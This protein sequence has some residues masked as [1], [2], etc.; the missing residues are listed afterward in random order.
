M[1]IGLFPLQPRS[2]T[3]RQLE[4]KP[5]ISGSPDCRPWLTDSRRC[6]CVPSLWLSESVVDEHKDKVF[7][8]K[9][10][11][12]EKYPPHPPPCSL[13]KCSRHSPLGQLLL[14]FILN[15]SLKPHFSSWGFSLQPNPFWYPIQTQSRTPRKRNNRIGSRFGRHPRTPTSTTIIL[16]STEFS[17]NPNETRNNDEFLHLV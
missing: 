12:L 9:E 11:R 13:P 16:S 1:F 6:S 8:D 3:L 14:S 10:L 7:V 15:W 17:D 2:R 5:S 4:T